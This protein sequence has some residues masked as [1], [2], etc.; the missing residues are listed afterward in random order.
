MSSPELA[1]LIGVLRR[2]GS[3][4]ERLAA[5][6]RAW[7]QVKELPAWERAQLALH[8]GVDGAAE[9][10]E[11]LA[12]RRDGLP[13]QQLLSLLQD[14]K[15]TDPGRL[16]GF[17]SDLSNPR[18]WSKLLERGLEAASAG[19]EAPPPAA[20]PE[21]A[22]PQPE[23]TPVL[24]VVPPPVRAERAV[25]PPPSAS[26]PAMERVSSKERRPSA[27][28]SPVETP[29]IREETPVPTPAAPSPRPRLAAPGAFDRLIKRLAAPPA[30]TSFGES[31]PSS[32]MGG[33]AV[34][35]FRPCCAQA[36]TRGS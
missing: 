14:V 36:S 2:T 31:S 30:P 17:V 1:V 6:F 34:A 5:L 25:P 35:P 26:P 20:K 9:L 27:P 15:D 33:P 24:K 23:Q 13:A 32:P 29:A 11:E 12:E 22:A 18:A 16:K 4:R 3:P 19:T 28:P 21:S 10:V 7:K 8:L